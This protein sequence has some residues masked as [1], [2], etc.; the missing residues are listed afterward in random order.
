M[1][2]GP[3]ESD[4]FAG[5]IDIG[6]RRIWLEC[7]GSGGPTVVLEPGYPHR[8]TIALGASTDKPA[9]LPGVAAFTRV[10]A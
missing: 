5:L 4:V 7:R 1:D 3:A 10:C 6:G 8:A 2:P 9:V